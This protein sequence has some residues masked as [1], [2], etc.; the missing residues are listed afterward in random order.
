MLQCIF[1][2][3]CSHSEIYKSRMTVILLHTFVIPVEYTLAL[4]IVNIIS[5]RIFKFLPNS[6]N[7]I[8][9]IESHNWTFNTHLQKIETCENTNVEFTYL[10]RKNT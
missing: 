5:I 10:K 4:M 7:I 6:A 2:C 9:V 8:I 3:I 1:Q